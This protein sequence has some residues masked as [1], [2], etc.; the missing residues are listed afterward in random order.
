MIRGALSFSPSR[1]KCGG[2]VLRRKDTCE[3]GQGNV[4][5]GIAELF[6]LAQVSNGLQEPGALAFD[7]T[8][9]VIQDEFLD[10]KFTDTSFLCLRRRRYVVRGHR[11]GTVDDLENDLVGRLATQHCIPQRIDTI[12]HVLAAHAVRI[13][14]KALALGDG[15]AI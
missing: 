13:G 11:K 10:Q 6:L 8:G 3:G 4:F 1:S 2:T 15:L 9:I 5:T 7:H 12:G 14:D